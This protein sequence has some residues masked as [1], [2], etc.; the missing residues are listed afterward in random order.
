MINE[1]L[2]SKYDIPTPRY[3]SYPTVPYWQT[4]P[5]PESIWE[6][7]LGSS[8][9]QNPK[10]SLYLH[11]PFCEILCT[12]CGCNK[13]ITKN[14]SLE[15]PY[16]ESLLK[17][18]HLYSKSFK[19]TPVLQEL[20]LGGG[21]PTFFS[22]EN[23]VDFLTQLMSEMEIPAD[24]DLSFEAHPSSTT[25][26]HIEKLGKIGFNRISLGIQDFS[27]DILTRINR[28]QTLEQIEKIT[29]VA[30][31][32]N[33]KSINY[34]LIYGLPGQTLEHIRHNIS[35][36]K[37]LKPDRIAFYSYAHVPW[38][39]PGQRA[40]SEKDL[41]VGIEKQRL[42]ELGKQLLIENGYLPIGM[43]HFALPTDDLYQAFLNKNLHRNFMGYTPKDTSVLLGLG[44]SAISSNENTYIQNH[45]DLEFYQKKV[46][47][48]QIPI[49]KGHLLKAEEQETGKQ[50][51]NILCQNETSWVKSFLDNDNG[52]Q[53]KFELS[54]LERDGLILLQENGLIVTDTGKSYLRNICLVFDHKYR[55]NK[56]VNPLFSKSI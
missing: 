22:S 39:K 31:L 12:Y 30:R 42:F 34:D 1:K 16:L 37:K 6:R 25:L 52:K 50:I 41:P 9:I 3:T 19:S 15:K 53:I 48:G 14:H 36:I 45:R 29:H 56:P 4:E 5:I 35:L 13:R 27:T 7:R 32:N 8:L 49:E 40:Y 11:L 17:E 43:D 46:E 28:F 38:V 2:L 23:L 21:T 47:N 10:I 26:T 51:K 44:V 54:E 24:A 55:A 20:H 33:Y 18:W